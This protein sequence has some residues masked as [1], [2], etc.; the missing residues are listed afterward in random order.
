MSKE[1]GPLA[2]AAKRASYCNSTSVH[3]KQHCIY[4]ILSARDTKMAQA[5]TQSIHRDPQLLYG[6]SRLN[7]PFFANIM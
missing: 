4:E 3:K 6:L 7:S 2:R 5:P 1:P